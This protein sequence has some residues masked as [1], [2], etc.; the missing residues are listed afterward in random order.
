[1]SQMRTIRSQHM[2]RRL[3][4]S[5]V[6]LSLLPAVPGL[7]QSL[8]DLAKKERE[9]QQTKPKKVYTN[10]DLNKYE[11]L[12][13][14]VPAAP[15]DGTSKSAKPLLAGPDDSSERAWSKRFIEAKARVQDSKTK[16]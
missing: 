5:V 16:A 15:A 12:R 3:L 2:L 11:D 4:A 6:L 1:M 10:E 8:A 14:S 7:C 9:K 13:S